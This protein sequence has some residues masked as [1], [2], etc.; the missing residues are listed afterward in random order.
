MKTIFILD[1]NRDRQIQMNNNLTAM[2]Y[3]VR[4]FS[5]AADFEGVNEKPFVI[6]LDEKM[7]SGERSDLLFLKK[8]SK[9]M[10]GVPIVYTMST[11]EKKLVNDA[12]KM[13]AYSVIEKNSA[14]FVNLR[15]ALDEIVNSPKVSWF[16]R[17]F[18]KKQSNTLPA[19]SV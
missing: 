17:L 1:E 19:L 9:K 11:S 5:S 18:P 16:A 14:E 7:Q 6:V 10:S 12:K 13:G 2:G 8:I 15:T 3:S 4:C